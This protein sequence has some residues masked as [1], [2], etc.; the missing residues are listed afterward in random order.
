MFF[1]H[2]NPDLRQIVTCSVVLHALSP[3]SYPSQ[4]RIKNHQIIYL[5]VNDSHL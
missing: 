5:Y 4:I 2:Y 1:T 3:G